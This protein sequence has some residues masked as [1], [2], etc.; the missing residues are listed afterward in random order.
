MSTAEV[1]D[2]LEYL[3]PPALSVP[4]EPYGLQVGAPTAEVGAIVVAPMV[5][6]PSMSTAASRKNAILVTAAPL[7]FE[8]LM[9]VRRDDPIGSKLAYLIE[10]RIAL[11]CLANSYAAAPGGFDDCLAEKLGL[12]GT[13]PLKPST[14][15]PLLK[16]AVFTPQTAVDVVLAAASEA[17]AGRIG[18]YTECSFQTRGT[19]TFR[20]GQGARPSVGEVG[21]L[22]RVDEVR[23]EMV[24]PQREL[25]GVI[26]AVI[27]AH[28]YEEV[29]YDVIPVRNPGLAYGRGRF[30]ELPLKV[31]LD[32]VLA[33]VQDGLEVQSVRCSH[34]PEFA[35]GSMAVA[36]GHSDG[37]FWDAHR[38][39]A[40]AFVVGGLSTRDLMSA[41]NS[42]TVVIEVGFPAS[43][44]PGLQWLS[45]QLVGTFEADGVEIVSCA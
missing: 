40:G 7:L 37:L 14:Y 2:F 41:D 10:H 11:Y 42:T 38:A 1:I 4:E 22:E 34:R 17:G 44:R 36:S 3:A 30:G 33:Q 12:A 21:R 32:T 5:S 28:P 29:A 19:G 45:A 18:N 15:E 25:S 8:P 13:T 43:V 39:G 26:A 35:I 24:V 27:E 6:F 16:I 9:A 20:G 23:L 31:S